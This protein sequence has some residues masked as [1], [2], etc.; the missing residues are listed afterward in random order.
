[1]YVLRIRELKLDVVFREITKNNTVDHVR[2]MNTL[3]FTANIT[4]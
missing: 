1:M 4:V 2:K 3:S